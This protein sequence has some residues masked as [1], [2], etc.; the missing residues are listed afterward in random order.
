MKYRYNWQAF[1][2]WTQHGKGPVYVS[3][4]PESN[5]YITTQSIEELYNVLAQS[6]TIQQDISSVRR[7]HIYKGVGAIPLNKA[8]TKTLIKRR[9]LRS[10][11]V[12]YKIYTDNHGALV[13]YGDRIDISIEEL[14][15]TQEKLMELK[16]APKSTEH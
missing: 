15:K 8:A 7:L 3:V 5:I 4:D 14:A 1:K 16:D 13:I 6:P 2:N 9:N 10:N 11:S 12:K